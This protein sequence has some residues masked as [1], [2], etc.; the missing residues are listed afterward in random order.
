M[1]VMLLRRL[2]AAGLV[3]WAATLVVFGLFFIAPTDVARSLLGK[4]SAQ[5]PVLVRNVTEQ[6]GLDRPIY[7]Q[8]VAFIGR[9][10][11]GDLGYS[12]YNNAPVTDLIAEA[13]PVTASLVL[14]AAVIWL[15]IGVGVGVR[16]ARRPHGV[17]DR[18]SGAAAL[19]G[20]SVP[21]FLM[22]LLLLYLLYFQ[23]HLVGIDLF[24]GGGY[25]AFSSDP[26]GWARHLVLPWAAM[27]ISS[28]GIYVRLTRS[29][30]LETLSG[31]FIVSARAKGLSE[32]R[33]VYRHGLRAAMIPV[34]TQ[35]GIDVATLLGGVVVTEQVFGLNGIGRLSVQAVVHRDQPVIIGVVLLAAAAVVVASLAVDLIYLWLDPRLRLSTRT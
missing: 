7:E 12:Y 32:R 3:L 1:I 26:L 15:V 35:L 18:I 20:L 22:G 34:V 10:L 16:S 27:V 24:P 23:L 8:Y 11:Q 19:V 9:L 13:F 6:L 30:M 14:G 17:F 21:P 4:F 5:D 31:D 29:Q 28:V 25:V 33:V 2:L